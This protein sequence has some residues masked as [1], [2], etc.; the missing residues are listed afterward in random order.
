MMDPKL[1]HY[2]QLLPESNWVD[3]EKMGD[4]K[5]TVTIKD[6]VQQTIAGYGKDD[7]PKNAGIMTFEETP[8]Q[9]HLCKTNLKCLAAMFG[10]K[11]HDWIGKRV[12]IFAG[13][14]KREPVPRVWGSPDIDHSFDVTITLKRRKPFKMTMH[15]T[16]GT[17]GTQ[18]AAR[19]D[20]PPPDED[21]DYT[22]ELPDDESDR[23]PGQEG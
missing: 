4:K 8:K 7:P 21:P 3:A 19:A 2:G 9:F 11:L 18:K 10:P 14:W 22:P 13:T 1:T 20:N 17:N 6:I 12:T 16:T 15:K 23:I 5:P